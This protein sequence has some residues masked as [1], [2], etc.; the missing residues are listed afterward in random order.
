MHGTCVRC[1]V[2]TERVHLN[3]YCCLKC[4]NE[5]EKPFGDV[6]IKTGWSCIEIH[7]HNGLTN[8]A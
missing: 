3:A 7:S 4:S 1:R 5:E 6:W 8:S 2:C